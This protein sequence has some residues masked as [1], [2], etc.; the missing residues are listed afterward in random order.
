MLRTLDGAFEQTG[1]ARGLEVGILRADSDHARS[2][3]TRGAESVRRLHLGPPR[4]RAGTE[5]FQARATS[6]GVK[7]GMSAITALKNG[8]KIR[9][10]RRCGVERGCAAAGC[11]EM[12]FLPP[13]I[14]AWKQFSERYSAGSSP[15]GAGEVALIV[16]LVFLFNKSFSGIG[17]PSGR[18]WK[19]GGRVDENPR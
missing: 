16:L 2:T 10:Q 18:A 6:L 9:Q 7:V 8:I 5:E 17:R 19:R 3:P 12:E 1:A 13:K 15:P 14:S 4:D 11:Q